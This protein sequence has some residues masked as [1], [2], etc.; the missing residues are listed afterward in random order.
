MSSLIVWL[1]SKPNTCNV[2]EEVSAISI[3][4]SPEKLENF[5][6]KKQLFYIYKVAK[7]KIILCRTMFTNLSKNGKMTF[8]V[9][10]FM[11]NIL[12]TKMYNKIKYLIT[13]KSGS[14]TRFCGK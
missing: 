10:C 13:S 2:Q 6:N 11:I 8:A 12:M 4:Q 7:L 3:K 5:R 14:A 9:I 1:F